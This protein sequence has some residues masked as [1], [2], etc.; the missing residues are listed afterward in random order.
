MSRAQTRAG[1]PGAVEGRDPSCAQPPPQD[2]DLP[3]YSPAQPPGGVEE[4][5]V[6]ASVPL[7]PSAE[8]SATA[9]SSP[10]KTDYH[11]ARIHLAIP[12]P[13]VPPSILSGICEL[14]RQAPRSNIALDTQG[15]GLRSSCENEQGGSAVWWWN[16]V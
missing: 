6:L 2:M 9:G 16:V 3:S 5:D 7:L 8:D 13:I 11:P 14:A 1:K 4:G 10:H 12:I 15:H